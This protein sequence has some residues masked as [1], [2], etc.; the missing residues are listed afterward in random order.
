MGFK[1]RV[2]SSGGERRL[3]RPHPGYGQPV[4]DE[5]PESTYFKMI[6]QEVYVSFKETLKNAKRP[7]KIDFGD[8]VSR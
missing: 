3:L 7:D 4:D 8:M 2:G 6:Y 1:G 5:N